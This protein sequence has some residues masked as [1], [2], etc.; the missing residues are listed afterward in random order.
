MRKPT[1]VSQMMRWH[2]DAV[3]GKKPPIHDGDPQFGWFKTRMVK[4]GPFVPA[5]IWIDREICPETGEL[6][7]DEQFICEVDGERRDAQREWVWLSKAP[8]SKAEFDELCHLRSSIEVMAA[9]HVP[10]DLQEHVIRP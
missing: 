9:T 8:I 10:F 2:A 3:A 7:C 6:A 4:G 1:P 5:R